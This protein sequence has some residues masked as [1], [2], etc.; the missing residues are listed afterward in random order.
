[1]NDYI[2]LFIL[3]AV[4]YGLLAI[5]TTVRL[6]I[7]LRIENFT[8][9][10]KR[11]MSSLVIFGVLVMYS[12]SRCISLTLASAGITSSS[13]ANYEQNLVSSIPAVMF[14]L[15]QTAML[16]KWSIH[17]TEMTHLLRND[18]FRLGGILLT[19]SIGLLVTCV[20]LPIGATI[21]LVTD[22]T[23]AFTQREWN[24]LLQLF[25]GITYTFNG[26]SFIFLGI[27]LRVLWTPEGIEAVAA[28]RRILA[29]A[30]VFGLACVTRGCV[31][32][33]Y[34][35]IRLL[36]N[37]DFSKRSISKWGEPMIYLIEWACVTLS[38][39]VL[40]V[41]VAKQRQASN[42][43]VVPNSNASVGRSLDARL[44]HDA[45]SDMER[46]GSAPE[47]ANETIFSKSKRLLASVVGVIVDP[48][49][50]GDSTIYDAS[51]SRLS[52]GSGARRT[53]STDSFGSQASSGYIPSS[54][55]PKGKKKPPGTSSRRSMEAYNHPTE[56]QP[57]LS[58]S[59]GAAPMGGG[60]SI[61]RRGGPRSL[62]YRPI[63]NSSVAPPVAGTPSTSS[64]KI[65]AVVVVPPTTSGP[66]VVQRESINDDDSAS[67]PR[68][69]S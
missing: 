56:K 19:S 29:I 20:I 36:E 15:L 31:L 27:Y 61:S 13:V 5:V 41:S 57:I 6:F 17:V 44:S 49:P 25:F 11:D 53:T 1:M 50:D 32:L 23:P 7:K 42:A 4:L 55:K 58:S 66:A 39:T 10:D 2:W 30:I 45:A 14:L 33:G 52:N 43:P 54:T 3:V 62:S 18:R 28:S 38:L 51:T 35:K 59:V 68:E 64:P 63:N 21:D 67:A 8:T 65:R 37:N 9:M 69:S 60:G 40:T 16:Y 24:F 47:I 22:T 12:M 46:G 48:I 34:L 26:A